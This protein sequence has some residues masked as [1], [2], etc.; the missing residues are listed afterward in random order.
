M[1]ERSRAELAR[2]FGEIVEDYDLGRPTYPSAA[3]RWL[4]NGAQKAIDL[5]A[6]TGKL[7]SALVALV[8]E[9]A[10]VELQLSMVTQ[11]NKTVSGARAV[12]G[13]AEAI[14]VRSQWADVLVVGQAFHWFDQEHALPEIAR[15]LKPGGRVGLVWNVRDQSIDWIAELSR[16]AGMDNSRKMR[17]DLKQIKHFRPFEIR[18]FP[19]VQPVDRNVLLANIRSRSHVAAMDEARRLKIMKAVVQLCDT[20]PDLAGKARFEFRY[21]T[22]AFRA[23]KE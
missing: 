12:C 1:P 13:R 6:G 19:M 9:V 17:S 2:S 8:P 21:Q 10:A 14:P 23:Q 22:Q 20:H 5:G 11:L 4:V 18:A 3:V 16:V 15:V 7:T